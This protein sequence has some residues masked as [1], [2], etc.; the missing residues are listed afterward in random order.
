MV[1][2]MASST[3]VLL[4]AAKLEVRVIPL[5]CSPWSHYRP[6]C[7][8]SFFPY[9]HRAG[10]AGLF[11][12]SV[13]PQLQPCSSQMWRWL[14]R[15]GLGAGRKQSWLGEGAWK[16]RVGSSEEKVVEDCSYQERLGLQG[17]AAQVEAPR[18]KQQRKGQA[19]GL[20]VLGLEEPGQESAVDLSVHPCPA[21]AT[22]PGGKRSSTWAWSPRQWLLSSRSW[23]AAGTGCEQQLFQHRNLQQRRLY[24][25]MKKQLKLNFSKSLFGVKEGER[26]R[27]VRGGGGVCQG[28]TLYSK[29]S[30]YG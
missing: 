15:G 21:P 25:V 20:K 12:C 3:K 30:P 29:G 17:W 23:A 18:S 8:R 2:L 4:I 9:T 7:G 6:A 19:V 16:A 10:P 22:P 24:N 5:F 27:E 28:F 14:G 13:F 26:K 1:W 11:S